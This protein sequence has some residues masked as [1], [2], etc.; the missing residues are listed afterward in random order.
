MSSVTTVIYFIIRLVSSV[1]V[2]KVK[3]SDW[4]IHYYYYFI[5]GTVSSVDVLGVKAS[6]WIMPY[7]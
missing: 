6:D 3:V 4:V 7:Y 5:V 1:G 2:L